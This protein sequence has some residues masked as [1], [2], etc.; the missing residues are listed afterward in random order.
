MSDTP[1]FSYWNTLAYLLFGPTYPPA[2][3]L[4]TT[5]VVKSAFE[6]EWAAQLPASQPYLL[7]GRSWFGNGPIAY[8]EI[9]TDGGQ[10]WHMAILRDIGLPAAWQLW[11]Y[12]WHTPSPGS[13][14]LQA[15]ATDITGATQPVTVPFNTLGYLFDGIVQHP[16]TTA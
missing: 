1:L 8:T 4:I 3:T 15:R 2:S 5:Q 11:E 16:I 7:T 6:L 14:T 10:S 12:P 13:Y 9:S